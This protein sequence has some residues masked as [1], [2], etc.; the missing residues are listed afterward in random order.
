[1]LAHFQT[2]KRLSGVEGLELRT[3][4]AGDV[5]VDVRGNGDLFVKGDRFDNSI[6]IAAGAEAGSYVITGNPTGDA[7]TATEVNGGTEAVT[8]TG[9]TGDL[10]VDLKNGDDFVTFSGVDVE[11]RLRL[12]TGSGNDTV[13]FDAN[14]S[15]GADASIKTGRGDD[16][17][18]AEDLSIDGNLKL[19]LQSGDD[20]L[21]ATGLLVSQI[22]LADDI[23]AGGNAKVDAGRGENTITINGSVDSNL[24][25]AV[26]RSF[27]DLSA[28]LDA[29]AKG[30]VNSAAVDGVLANVDTNLD[31]QVG[32]NHRDLNAV[33]HGK[34]GAGL[35][36]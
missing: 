23:T 26:D 7:Q 11:N 35:N 29:N 16:T 36:V 32:L 14:S 21:T 25:S 22:D 15:I 8:V 31:A 4:L 24:L 28:G 19:K 6:T 3:M 13:S 34:L 33:A 17:F 5:S 10:H 20:I 30:S 27:A 9:V 2:R 12:H 18:L 1:M